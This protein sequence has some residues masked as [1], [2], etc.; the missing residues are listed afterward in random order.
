MNLRVSLILL[1]IGSWVAVGATWIIDSDFGSEEREDQ[2][3]FFYNI[4]VEDIVHITLETQG[5]EIGFHYRENIR[6]WYFDDTDEYVEVPADLFRFGGITTL[7]GGPRTARFL[8]TEIQDPAQYGL[9]NPSSRYTIGLR[10]GEERVL[11][12]GD[13][14]VNGESTYAQMEG[15]PNLV[16]VDTSWSQVLNRLVNEPPVPDW[17]YSLNPDQVREVLLFENNEVVRAYGIDRDSGGFRLCDLPVQQDPCTG[18]VEADTDAFRAAMEL[19]AERRING[20][21]ALALDD[22]S[23]FV[24]YGTGRDSPYMTI[25]VE[26]ASVTQPNVTNVT[27]VSMTIGDVTP[28]G[29]YRYAVANETSDVILFEREWADQILELFHGDPLVATEG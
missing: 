26:Q 19:I 12:I 13:L 28:D 1:I 27:R 23:Q 4:P 15:L 8:N 2:P 6:R 10:N 7:L 9:D 18:T 24:Q 29:E 22:D 11:L 17:V 16:L 25:R 20:A 21:V 3:P 5:T 14:T